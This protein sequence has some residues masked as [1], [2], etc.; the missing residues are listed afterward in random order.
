MFSSS[1]IHG[2]RN[3]RHRKSCV[4]WLADLR[5]RLCV[6]NITCSSSAQQQ[7][8]LR[9]DPPF[10]IVGK[11]LE[12]C[13][14]NDEREHKASRWVIRTP[15][16]LFPARFASP[17]AESCVRDSDLA[18]DGI[19]VAGLVPQAVRRAAMIFTFSGNTEAIDTQVR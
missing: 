16:R 11:D 13:E 1:R 19:H 9:S 17:A 4:C 5:T 12:R 2:G 10:S 14:C 7:G 18:I 3:C 6:Q 15:T 8:K